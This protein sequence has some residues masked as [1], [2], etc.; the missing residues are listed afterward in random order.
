MKRIT[1]LILALLTAMSLFGCT[2]AEVPSETTA[3]TVPPET[4]AP[5]ETTVPVETSAP[6]ETTIPPETG[7]SEEELAVQE[8]VTVMLNAHLDNMF[9][10]TDQSFD[11]C[12]ILSLT[13]E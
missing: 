12:T 3:D 2:A 6:I 13:E 10:Y 11:S 9:L 7:P 5:V 8:V 4:T 1:S